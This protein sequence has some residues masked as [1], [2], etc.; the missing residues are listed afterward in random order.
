MNWAKIRKSDY[1]VIELNTTNQGFDTNV[2]L[3]VETDFTFNSTDDYVFN[4][5]SS[6][7]YNVGVKKEVASPSK[8]EVQASPFASA[9][10]FRFRGKGFSGIAD[11]SLDGKI[12]ETVIDWEV[13]EDRFINGTHVMLNGHSFGDSYD[14]EIVDKT[15][16]FAGILYPAQ[17]DSTGDGTAMLDWSVVAPSGVVLDT[18][19]KD[20]HV[21][22]DMQGQKP[23]LLPY[24]AKLLGGMFIRMRYKTIEQVNDVKINLNGFMHLKSAV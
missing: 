24:P 14:V 16:S 17:Y 18:F 15:Y 11:R 19:I 5:N 1:K 22:S 9:D 7:F 20:W 23:I 13:P 21:V 8:T 12:K 10:N 3:E 2:F 4:P 6:S